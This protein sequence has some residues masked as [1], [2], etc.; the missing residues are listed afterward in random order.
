MCC[1][2]PPRV[3]FT[4]LKLLRSMC[5]A[6]VLALPGWSVVPLTRE[7]RRQPVFVYVDAALD[8]GGVPVGTF[9]AGAWFAVN[10]MLMRRSMGGC[11][12]WDFFRWSLVRGQRCPLSSRRTSNARRHVLS[13]GD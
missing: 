11:T 8:G 7:V 5:V 1:A 9:F 12:G 6:C 2:P 10:C 3:E 4:P 13:C